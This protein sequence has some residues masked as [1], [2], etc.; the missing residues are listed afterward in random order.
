MY[1][2]TKW[3]IIKNT[4]RYWFCR[5]RNT[6]IRTVRAGSDPDDLKVLGRYKY[7]LDCKNNISGWLN[8][9]KDEREA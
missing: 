2:P 8:Q 6:K 5:H 1:T 3:E 7:C 4:F 9:T